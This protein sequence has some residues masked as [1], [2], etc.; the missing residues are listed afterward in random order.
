VASEDGVRAWPAGEGT[1]VHFDGR[2]F[3]RHRA[4]DGALLSVAA[5]GPRAAWAVGLEGGV[6]RAAGGS[7][8]ALQIADERGARLDVTLRAVA[9]RAPDDV[10]IAGDRATLLHWDG[11]SLSRVDARAAGADAALSAIVPPGKTDGWVVGPTGI[12]RIERATP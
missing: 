12:F 8:E 3:A 10:W 4:P 2:R 7:V 11:K 1:L 6:L 9:A 5:T